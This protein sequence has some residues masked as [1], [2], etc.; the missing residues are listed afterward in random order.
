MNDL[1]K[2]ISEELANATASAGRSIVSV[3]ARRHTPA[4]GIVFS[5]DGVIVTAHHVVER[6]EN[7]TVGLPNGS[8]VAATLVGRDLTTDL[9]VLRVQQTELEAARWADI[10]AVAV[11]QF[12]LALA[13]PGRNIQAT[14]GVISAVEEG[15][16]TSS[17]GMI[18]SYVQTDVLMYPGFSG[19][20]LMSADG[21][22]VGLN[23]SALVRGA[24][25]T[26]PAATVSRVVATLL[27]HGHIKRGYLGVSA[28]PVR[29]PVALAE[30]LAQETGLLIASV[31]PGSPAE[32]GGLLLGDTLVSLADH[33]IRHMDDLMSALSGERVGTSVSARVVRGG[34]LHEVS[35]VIGERN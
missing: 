8:E 13:R 20:P 6:D 10:G 29:L 19:G 34:Q 5:A 22:F 35:V 24:S 31:E 17:G 33:A 30:S 25:V 12:A 1:L 26:I 16:R 21:S 3:R 7:I 2:S 28:Q 11:G 15:W 4:S 9:A 27:A 23:S 32:Q 18:D 14:W